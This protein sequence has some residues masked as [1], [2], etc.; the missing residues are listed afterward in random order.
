[1]GAITLAAAIWP[2]VGVQPEGVDHMIVMPNPHGLLP[3]GPLYAGPADSPA[4]PF[5]VIF[6]L[7]IASILSLLA[8]Y[9][10]SA[11]IERLQ[12]RWLVAGLAAVAIAVPVGFVLFAAFGSAIEGWAWL[13]AIVA[14]TL[15]PIAIGIAVLRYR[16]YEIDRIISR[17]I[18]WAL[19]TGVLVAVF[20][21]L[22]VGFQALLAQI[23]QAET[24]AVA[25]STLVVFALF[26]PIRRRVQTAV[27]RRFDRARYDG[28]RTAAAFT[29]R[30]REQVDLAGP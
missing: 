29:E 25:A 22:V 13:P 26:Q 21:A 3:S 2:V 14:L 8:R 20:V 5:A 9:A 11:G 1:M 15:P 10:R 27:D 12:L 7:L 24:L 18:G 6:V 17:T 4:A 16:L 19:V 23:T 28:D 30:L